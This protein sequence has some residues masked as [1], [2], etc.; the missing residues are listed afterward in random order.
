MLRS[1]LGDSA[2][3]TPL[4]RLIIE[5]TQ[6]NPFFMEETFEM[7]LDECG[8]QKFH[9]EQNLSSIELR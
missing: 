9:R 2:E 1:L 8:Y 3:L 5:K 4:K 7:M 6:G